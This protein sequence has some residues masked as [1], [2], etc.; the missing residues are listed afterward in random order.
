MTMTSEAKASITM[1]YEL[2][3][4][5]AKVWRALTEPKLVEKWLMKADAAPAV[6]GKVTLRLEPTQWWDGIVECEVLEL[7]P[8]KRLRYTWR[9]GPAGP[10]KLDTVVTW[11]LTPTKSGGTRLML[12]HSGFQPQQG[13]AYG[14]AQQ[15]WARNINEPLRAVLA[16]MDA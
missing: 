11:T 4:P 3:H 2:P 16:Q 15:G 13:F 6:G 1:V 9:G 10:A 7:E 8:H 12:E 14:G 5:P